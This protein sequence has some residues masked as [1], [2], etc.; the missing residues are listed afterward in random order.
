MATPAIMQVRQGETAVHPPLQFYLG[1]TWEIPVSCTDVDGAPLDLESA[2]VVW[3]LNEPNGVNVYQLSV[4]AGIT[5]VENTSGDL[6]KGEALIEL[7]SARSGTLAAGFFLD[8][9][10]VVTGDGKTLTQFRGRI[11]AVAK[12]AGPVSG[13]G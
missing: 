13:G 12:L 9:L 3:V 2:S 6:V 8:E 10:T 5:L 1:D 11:E 4:G 7:I